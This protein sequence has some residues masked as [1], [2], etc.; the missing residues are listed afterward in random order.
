MI[1]NENKIKDMDLDDEEHVRKHMRVF[2]SIRLRDIS[3]TTIAKEQSSFMQHTLM[4]LYIV[5]LH[6]SYFESW[7]LSYMTCIIVTILDIIIHE[8]V[9]LQI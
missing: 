3:W 1:K 8:H 2:E 6:I 4:L 9:I 5:L 7:R